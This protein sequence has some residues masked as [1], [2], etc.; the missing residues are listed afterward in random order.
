[1][2]N[3]FTGAGHY[4]CDSLVTSNGRW[5]IRMECIERQRDQA[6]EALKNMVACFNANDADSMVNAA[7]DAVDVITR[8]RHGIK[9]EVSRA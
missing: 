2:R 5:Y 8:L 1:M 3:S 7:R 9:K 4:A 6:V